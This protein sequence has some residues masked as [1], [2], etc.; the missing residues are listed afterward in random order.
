MDPD[1]PERRRLVQCVS[2]EDAI[3]RH[4]GLLPL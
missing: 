3:R 2:K 4:S 1:G